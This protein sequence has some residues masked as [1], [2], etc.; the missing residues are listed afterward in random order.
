MIALVLAV[1]LTSV[2]RFATLTGDLS[3]NFP[4]L[5]ATLFG[6]VVVGAAPVFLAP[7]PSAI[8]IVAGGILVIGVL[9]GLAFLSLERFNLSGQRRRT[10]ERLRKLSA[11][12]YL[13]EKRRLQAVVPSADGEPAALSVVCWT[14]KGRTY[15]DQTEARRLCRT[16]DTRWSDLIDGK[17][18]PPIGEIVLRKCFLKTILWPWPPKFVMVVAIDRP[19]QSSNEIHR[20]EVNNL[21]FFDVSDLGLVAEMP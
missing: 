21:G 9:V 4:I 3:S 15:L 16:A 11:D 14:H 2:G 6:A 13:P 10:H 5:L 20:V 17:A 7:A 19:G 1:A 12:G 8:L 18:A